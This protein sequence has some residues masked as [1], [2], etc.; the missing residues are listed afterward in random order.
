[1]ILIKMPACLEVCEMQGSFRF[2]G[3]QNAACVVRG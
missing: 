1:L 3:Q 2:A